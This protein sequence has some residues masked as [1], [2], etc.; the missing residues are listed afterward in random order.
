MKRPVYAHDSRCEVC[1]A[2]RRRDRAARAHRRREALDVLAPYLIVVAVVLVVAF[3][4][5]VL[6]YGPHA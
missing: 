1:V 5:G 2:S 6:G 4:N 3:A